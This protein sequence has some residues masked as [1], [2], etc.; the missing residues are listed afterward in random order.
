ML[1]NKQNLKKVT[2]KISALQAGHALSHITVLAPVPLFLCLFIWGL[3][4]KSSSGISAETSII[5]SK[6]KP[7]RHFSPLWPTTPY[8]VL[9]ALL[10][11]LCTVSPMFPYPLKPRSIKLLGH[12]VHNSLNSDMT[13]KSSAASPDLQA[14]AF[15][16]GAKEQGKSDFSQLLDSCLYHLSNE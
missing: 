5:G 11:L 10:S 8:F 13:P 16:W 9:L 3:E 7:W 2:L 1:F 4:Q 15:P 12:F 14:Y 6:G